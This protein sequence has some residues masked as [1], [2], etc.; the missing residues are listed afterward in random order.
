VEALLI[1]G[2]IAAVTA[3]ASGVGGR[4]LWVRNR[5][6]YRDT[7]VLT[8]AAADAA[9]LELTTQLEA[10]RLAVAS[11]VSRLGPNDAAALNAEAEPSLAPAIALD[12]RYNTFAY[13]GQNDPSVS[14][15]RHVYQLLSRQYAEFIRAFKKRL[16]EVSAMAARCQ[17][18][19]EMIVGLEGIRLVTES[20]MD[21]AEAAIAAQGE[22]GW[23]MESFIAEFTALGDQLARAKSSM[24]NGDSLTALREFTPV[25][26]GASSLIARI[27]ELPRQ[28][29]TMLRQVE[30]FDRQR[31]A[32][33]WDLTRAEAGLRA[34]QGVYAE[35][36]YSA[37]VQS[38]GAARL[39]HEQLEAMVAAAR[40][41]IDPKADVWG[42][43]Q[44]YV[45]RVAEV[46]EEIASA[47]KALIEL[48]NDLDDHKDELITD[49]E[50]LRTRITNV[51][52][53]TRDRYGRQGR[54]RRALQKVDGETVALRRAL[55]DPLPD[56]DRLG[57]RLDELEDM[58]T[59]L[60]DASMR[61]DQDWDDDEDDDSD[62]LFSAIVTG[63]AIAIGVDLTT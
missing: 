47:C 43:A 58:V 1:E 49:S 24:A 57:T 36:A 38:L 56:P 2:A 30:T 25:R 37:E 46:I 8:R 12:A 17:H 13:Q 42:E 34:V 33:V 5:N 52:L 10:T 45:A 19:E 40:A 60:D 53:S 4:V 18:I 29:Q 61:I 44:I 26:H 55:D 9:Y 28:I 32:L 63:A 20:I 54:I 22:E 51:A 35:T 48:R 23:A 62:S 39:L 15:S 27:R 7:A 3:V 50:H 6:G 11:L 59:R 41:C 31:A 21:E 14:Q 16:A